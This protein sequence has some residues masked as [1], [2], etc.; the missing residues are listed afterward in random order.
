[1]SSALMN[2][3]RILAGVAGVE[4]LRI[5]TDRLA[6]LERFVKNVEGAEDYHRPRPDTK[7]KYYDADLIEAAIAKVKE[8]TP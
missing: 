2:A 1:M 3:A 8:P 6:L 5:K 7:L 4:E